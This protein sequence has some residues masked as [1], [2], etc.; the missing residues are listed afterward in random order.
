MFKKV[1]NT[2]IIKLLTA[3]INLVI[4]ILIS[5]W[6]GA[7]GKGEQSLFVATVSITIYISGLFGYIPV[8]YLTSQKKTINYYLIGVVWAIISA[9]LAYIILS[10]TSLIN[11]KYVFYISIITFFAGLSE[12]NL[13]IFMIRERIRFYNLAFFIQPL[14]LIIALFS[15]FFFVDNFT[16]YHFIYSFILSHI[17]MFIGSLSG[18]YIYFTEI[19]N[20]KFQNLLLDFLSMLRYGFFNQAALIFQLIAIRGSFYVLEKLSSIESVG[21]F[22]NGIAIIES[23]RIINRSLALVFYSRVINSSD[24]KYT[25][26]LFNKFSII[27]FWLQI[28]ALIVIA[29]IPNQVYIFLFGEDFSSL[30]HIIILLMPGAIFYGQSFMSAHYF[31]GKGKHH[32]NM[33]SNI[34][35]MIFVIILCF[36]L[37]PNYDINGAIWATN[38]GYIFL[39]IIQFYFI[40][41]KFKVSILSQ[42]YDKE[43]FTEFQQRFLDYLKERGR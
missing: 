25:N 30:K 21:I 42:V 37:V 11:K 40:K 20:F 16:I 4:A 8:C 38:V 1:A 41:K 13:T 17:I 3:L 12:V 31:S 29:I 35:N 32:I 22:S 36:V 39:F 26:K 2:F 28:S 23:L 7:G 34:I 27:S 5:Q 33:I 43:T 15:F 9:L 6:L 18:S 10:N 24:E 19:R 14:S